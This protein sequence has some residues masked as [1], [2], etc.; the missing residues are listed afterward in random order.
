MLARMVASSPRF[1]QDNADVLVFTFKEGLLSAVAHDLK[2]R[3]TSFAVRVDE[4]TNAIEATF[5]PRSLRVVGAMKDGADARGALSESDRHKIEENILDDVL[6]V[7][8]HP[9]IRF[10]STSVEEDEGGT[11]YRVRGKLTLCGQTHEVAFVSRSDGEGQVA[12]V[13]LHQPTWGIKPYSAMLGTLKIQPD[14]MVRIA[15]PGAL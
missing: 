14:V 9:E 4:A 11:G 12:E 10:V 15:L 1:H 6:H 3:V 7:K 5:D 2:I 13:K 8:K